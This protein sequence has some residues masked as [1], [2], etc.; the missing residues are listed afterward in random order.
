MKLLFKPRD[1][2][3]LGEGDLPFGTFDDTSNWLPITR[4]LEMGAEKIPR[5]ILFKVANNDGLLK[6][7]Y[8]YEQTNGW[9]NRVAN[10]L[11]SKHEIKKGDKVGIY[12]QGHSPGCL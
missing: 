9:A 12:G 4:Y 3:H 5:K 7:Q 6:E 8:T 11:S 2:K 10:G 1:E